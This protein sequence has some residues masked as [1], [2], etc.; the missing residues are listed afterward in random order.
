MQQLK[1]SHKR[2]LEDL[3][4]LGTSPRH[5]TKR[6]QEKKL[7]DSRKGFLSGALVAH[8]IVRCAKFTQNNMASTLGCREFYKI[9]KKYKIIKIGVWS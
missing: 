9:S 7:E 3:Q 6:A 5:K 4:I 1:R 2:L 8:W